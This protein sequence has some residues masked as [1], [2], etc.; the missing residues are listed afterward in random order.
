MEIIQ[1]IANKTGRSCGLKL[2]QLEEE[3]EIKG[4]KESLVRTTSRQMK[5]SPLGYMDLS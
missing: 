4:S 2:E 1:G 3:G 5:V